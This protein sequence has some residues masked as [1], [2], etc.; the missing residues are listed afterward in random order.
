MRCDVAGQDFVTTSNISE[1]SI[2][3]IATR[4]QRSRK[5]MKNLQRLRTRTLKREKKRE[6]NCTLHYF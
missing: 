5:I 1:E 4:G 3:E 6:Q 2:H